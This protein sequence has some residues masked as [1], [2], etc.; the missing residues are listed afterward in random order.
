MK[1]KYATQN[2]IDLKV[3]LLNIIQSIIVFFSS[4]IFPRITKELVIYLAKKETIV[5]TVVCGKSTIILLA[6]QGW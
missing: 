5:E 2:T 6:Y 4:Y 3:V 1:V